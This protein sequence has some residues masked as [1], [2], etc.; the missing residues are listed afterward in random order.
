[1]SLKYTGS[2]DDLKAVLN[3]DNR[4]NALEWNN[5]SARLRVQLIAKS[6]LD[7]ETAAVE[8]FNKAVEGDQ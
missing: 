4:R 3:R 6:Y 1:M 7:V 2:F 8:R 5:G